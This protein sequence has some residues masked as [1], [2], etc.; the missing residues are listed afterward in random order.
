MPRLQDM[1]PSQTA[2]LFGHTAVPRSPPS[3]ASWRTWRGKGS[4][5][6][7]LLGPSSGHTVRWAK[8]WTQDPEGYY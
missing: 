2:T 1:Q 4:L 7:W 6:N 8:Q 5:T 3:S